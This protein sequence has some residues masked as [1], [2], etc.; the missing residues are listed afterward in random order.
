MGR[1]RVSLVI[2]Y[3]V[4]PADYGVETMEEAAAEER[5]ALDADLIGTIAILG[6]E[7]ETDKLTVEVV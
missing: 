4:N 6:D 7:S 5:K 3:E 1:L 2:E